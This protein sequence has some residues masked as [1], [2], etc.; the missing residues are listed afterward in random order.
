MRVGGPAARLVRVQTID[1][2][3]DAVHEVDDADEPLLVVGGGSNLVVADEGFP[4]TVVRVETTGIRVESDDRCGGANVRVAAGEQLGR[5]RRPRRRPRGGPGSRRCRGSPARPA[6]RRSRTSGPTARRSRR[7]SPRSASGTGAT[8]RCA[9]CS[10]RTAGSPTVTRGSSATPR[11]SWSSTCSSSCGW[12]TSP[13]RSDTG[14]WPVRSSV[15]LD[16]RVPL[17][18]ARAAVLE[19]RRE[20]RHGAGRGGPRHLELRLVLHQPGPVRGRMAQL[21]QPGPRAAGRRRPGASVWPEPDGRRKTSAAWLIERAGFEKG[22][23]TPGPAALSDKH[24]LAVTNRGSARTG[25]RAGARRRGPGRRGERVRDPAGQ[26]AG[27]R[28]RHPRHPT[29][30]SASL[31]YFAGTPSSRRLSRRSRR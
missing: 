27:A 18:D 13:N 25:R 8:V 26:R 14:T 19:Q 20:A 7:P 5:P 17:A 3:V 12:P 22:F 31:R 9:P 10:P 15:E 16:A 30:S 24:T 11:S 23:G 21:G 4:G 1:E 2:L 6:R 29:K 28:R